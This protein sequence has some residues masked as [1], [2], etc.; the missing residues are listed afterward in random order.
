MSHSHKEPFLEIKKTSVITPLYKKGNKF[1]PQNY[2]PRAMSSP[3]SKVIEKGVLY[4][5]E[6]YFEPNNL[7]ISSHGWPFHVLI[8]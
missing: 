5:L 1:D 6:H 4:R 3:I 7:L 2:R 8:I